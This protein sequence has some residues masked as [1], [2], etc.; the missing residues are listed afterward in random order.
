MCP[1]KT[2]SDFWLFW[3]GKALQRSNINVNVWSFG[4]EAPDFNYI[5]QGMSRFDQASYLLEYLKVHNIDD[6]VS[7]TEFYRYTQKSIE[8]V[9][10]IFWSSRRVM[11]KKEKIY[12]VKIKSV[13][14][15]RSLFCYELF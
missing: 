13:V 8:A 10:F 14:V 15:K 12:L 1:R 11:A 6:R 4:Y 3:L 7:G 9:L 5:G 2:D